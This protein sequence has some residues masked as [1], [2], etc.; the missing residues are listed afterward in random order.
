[1]IMSKLQPMMYIDHLD[2]LPLSYLK[3]RHLTN[4]IIDLDNTLGA[5]D[6]KKIDDR[7]RKILLHLIDEGFKVVVVSNNTAKRIVEFLGDLPVGYI[8]LALKPFGFGYRKALNRYGLKIEETVSIGD[9]ILTDILG[10]NLLGI[11]S[12][13]V[14]PYCERDSYSTRINRHIERYLI[15]KGVV[16]FK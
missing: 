9:Q 10:S 5:Y 13:L 16:R 6:Q 11:Y 3:Q 14:K 15:K 12:I 1:M 4:I 8:N 7:Y 2:D